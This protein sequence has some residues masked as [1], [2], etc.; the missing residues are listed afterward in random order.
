M[1]NYCEIVVYYL[2][3]REETYYG[4]LHATTTMLQIWPQHLPAVNIPLTAIRKYTTRKICGGTLCQK[5]G[6]G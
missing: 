5:N 3:G 4:G 6:D 1:S 2:D